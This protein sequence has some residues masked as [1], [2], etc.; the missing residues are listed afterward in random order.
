[1]SIFNPLTKLDEIYVFTTYDISLFPY[2]ILR[3]RVKCVFFFY[4]SSSYCGSITCLN[5]N[6]IRGV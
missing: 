5:K 3:E 4:Y 2:H 1:M 6:L